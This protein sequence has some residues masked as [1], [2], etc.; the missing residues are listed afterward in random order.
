[1]HVV[2]IVV[3]VV[4]VLGWGYLLW[5][6]LSGG[7]TPPEESPDQSLAAAV[8]IKQAFAQKM[9]GLDDDEEMMVGEDNTIRAIGAGTVHDPN[10]PERCI[11]YNPRRYE[12]ICGGY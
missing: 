5:K 4:F 9:A 1:M 6:T 7:S 10:L 8:S 3:A 12:S 11:Q 2:L